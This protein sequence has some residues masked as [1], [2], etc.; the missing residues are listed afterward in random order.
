MEP[1]IGIQLFAVT[2]MVIALLI[3]G[4]RD[5]FGDIFGGF[6]RLML[7]GPRAS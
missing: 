3:Y 4:L 6:Q 2:V 7:A 5:T 1:C